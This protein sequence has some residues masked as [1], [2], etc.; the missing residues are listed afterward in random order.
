MSF[1][2]EHYKILTKAAAIVVVLT[3]VLL[4]HRHHAVWSRAAERGLGRLARRQGLAVTLVG[5]LALGASAAASLLG[6]VPE[7]KVH[8]EFSYLLAADTFVHG[9]LGNPT[10]PMWVHFESFH[11]IHQPTYASKYPPAQGLMLAGGQLIG[12]HPIVGVWI[13]TGLACAAICWMLL[14]WLPRWWAMLGGLLAALHPGIAL[15]WG[16]CYWGGTVAVMGGALVFG[17]L[18]R[19]VRRPRVRHALL[20]GVGLAVLANSRPY[21][22]LVAS[23]PVAAALLAWMLGKKGPTARVSIGRIVVPLLTVLALT[24]GAMAAYNWSVTGDAL[25]MPYLV[26]EATYV[27]APVFLWQQP[28]P[29]PTYRHQVIRHFYTGTVRDIY[30]GADWGLTLYTT[31]RSLPGL[32]REGL[33]KF[34][35]LWRFYLWSQFQLGLI[36]LLVML[37]WVLHDRWARFA[38]ITCGVFLGGLFLETWVQVHYAAPVTGLV[39]A[40]V[41]QTMRHLRLWHWGRRLNGRALVWA[42]SAIALGAFLTAFVQRTWLDAPGWQ[43]ERARILAQLPANGRRHL[44]IVRYGPAHSPL[45]EWVYNAAD[46]DGAKV[47]WAREM[48]LAHDLELLEY[49]K[50]RQVWLA[51][52]DQDDSPPKLVPYPVEA[53]R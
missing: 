48:N 51:E 39:F 38:L 7:P 25:R 43:F 8:D 10:H 17:A 20:L 30:T 28:R 16:Q 9:R 32:A 37:P 22:G 13:S 52:V 15:Y 45:D 18:R 44:V 31:Q 12:G 46:I 1:F 40:L 14:A 21:E 5:L 23:L 33:R 34:D 47:V 19:I 4:T 42:V 24:G 41:L 27:V 6:H 3:I 2:V 26:H 29:E 49:F 50:D 35:T 11:I 53:R 36:F